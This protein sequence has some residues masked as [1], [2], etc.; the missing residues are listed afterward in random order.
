MKKTDDAKIAKDYDKSLKELND[1]KT[2][3]D[4]KLKKLRDDQMYEN[5]AT[6][7]SIDGQYYFDHTNTRKN[8]DT[9]YIEI[10]DTYNAKVDKFN[11]SNRARNKMLGASIPDVKGADKLPDKIDDTYRSFIYTESSSKDKFTPKKIVDPLADNETIVDL[12]LYK[13]SDI[14]DD[15]IDTTKKADDFKNDE[16]QNTIDNKLYTTN[17]TALRSERLMQR[18]SEIKS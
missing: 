16:L 7:G 11:E 18:T 2:E 15:V 5:S 3:Y 8:I 12:D 1:A 13:R 10:R 14:Q 17:R 9:N 6:N 4:T